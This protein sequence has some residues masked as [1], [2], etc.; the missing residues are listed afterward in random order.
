MLSKQ[1]TEI[2]QRQEL[3]IHIFVLSELETRYGI[4]AET[5]NN[6]VA[7]AQ[8]ING[9]QGYLSHVTFPYCAPEEVSTLNRATSYIFTG[10]LIIRTPIICT[11]LDIEVNKQKSRLIIM[12]LVYKV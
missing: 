7:A 9:A 8:N 5:R 1:I 3:T 4:A 2:S 12:S 10:M 11:Q 6:L